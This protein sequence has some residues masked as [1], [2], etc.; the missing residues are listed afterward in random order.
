[1]S[2]GFLRAVRAVLSV[3]LILGLAGSL[4]AYAWYTSEQTTAARRAEAIE[5]AN[6]VVT[7]IVASYGEQINRQILALDQTLATMAQEWEAD[8][9]RFNLEVS[10]ARSP[11]IS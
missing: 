3:V 1:M 11:V 5:Q 2:S 7:G 9:R 4:I 8:P 6:A 10:R